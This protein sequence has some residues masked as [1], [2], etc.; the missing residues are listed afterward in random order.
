MLVGHWYTGQQTFLD[1][2][3]L[4]C[5]TT[6]VNMMWKYFI[7]FPVLIWIIEAK[8]QPPTS[9]SSQVGIYLSY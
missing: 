6:K 7:V 9:L 2:G 3:K 5:R 4:Q 8:L 1:T